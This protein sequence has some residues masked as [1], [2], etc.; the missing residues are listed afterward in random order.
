[1]RL[2]TLD[3]CVCM[4]NEPHYH[5]CSLLSRKQVIIKKRSPPLKN[6]ENH[7]MAEPLLPVLSFG[8]GLL[9]IIKNDV[10]GFFHVMVFQNCCA[11]LID[12]MYLSGSLRL[13]LSKCSQRIFYHSS[14]SNLL[15]VD[16]S[17]ES[18][19]LQPDVIPLFD[20]RWRQ[21]TTAGFFLQLLWKTLVL[22][23]GV[24]FKSRWV[25]HQKS[26]FNLSSFFQL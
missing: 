15:R 24:C 25:R 9:M 14:R 1:M 16:F 17:K 20:A 19:Q 18:F 6:L 2:E 12:P 8:H 22:K 11:V 26:P 21:A 13:H 23:E 10:C 3:E 5:L 7:K 4:V